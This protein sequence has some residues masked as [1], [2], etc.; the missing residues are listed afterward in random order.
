MSFWYYDGL[1]ISRPVHYLCKQRAWIVCSNG[2][3]IIRR[4]NG[5]GLRRSV[6]VF[7]RCAQSV[8]FWGGWVGGR[9]IL[10]K[11]HRQHGVCQQGVLGAK[12]FETTSYLSFEQHYDTY[13]ASVQEETC[14]DEV[15][16]T[17]PRR[18]YLLLSF[19]MNLRITERPWSG[20][21]VK[22]VSGH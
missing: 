6:I 14:N 22:T 7:L 13:V 3:G 16:L 5:T 12:A 17:L 11:E 18:S 4:K 21:S 9:R 1:H 20:S 10:G 15:P 19:A 2:A 8:F